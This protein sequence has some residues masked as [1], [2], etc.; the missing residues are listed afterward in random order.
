MSKPPDKGGLNYYCEPFSIAHTVQ[1]MGRVRDNMRLSGQRLLQLYKTPIGQDVIETLAGAG[2]SA[3]GQAMFTDM[4]PEQ[5]AAS[6]VLGIGAATVGRPI[7]G[8]AGQALGTRISKANPRINAEA[9][10]LIAGLTNPQ[11]RLGPIVQTKLAPYAH[12]NAPAQVGQLVGRH[13]GD[14]IAQAAVALG[15]PLLVGEQ[16]NA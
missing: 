1:L 7:V 12:L 15:S 11:T 13:Y 6:T 8:S 9:E 2:V 10:A 5:I 16:D 14:N 4:T 3:T